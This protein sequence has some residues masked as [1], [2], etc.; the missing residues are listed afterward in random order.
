MIIQSKRIGA[1]EVD[2]SRII[3]FADGL[4]GFPIAK[5]FFLADDPAE[6][7]MPFKWLI[8]IEDPEL[9]FLVTDPGVFF[10]DYVFDLSA[11]DQKYLN[12][13]SP[14]DLSVITVLTVPA[15]PKLITANLKGP[16]VINWKTLVGRQLVLKDS[17]YETKHYIF[18]Q[19]VSATPE[20]A[21]TKNAKGMSSRELPNTPPPSAEHGNISVE[22]KV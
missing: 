6:E 9:M 4:L 22:G 3:R 21:A 8:C 14:E 18:M 12:V 19:A 15:D 7:G 16:L 2:E 17:A 20:V 13:K 5:S 1:V 11:E 10:K